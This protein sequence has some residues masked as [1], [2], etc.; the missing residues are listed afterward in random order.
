MLTSVTAWRSTG[1]ITRSTA[2]LPASGQDSTVPELLGV[3]PG[4]RPSGKVAA[5]TSS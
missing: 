2:P 1:R 5:P 4:L 3:Q